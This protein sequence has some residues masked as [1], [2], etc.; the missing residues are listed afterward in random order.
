MDVFGPTYSIALRHLHLTSHP[1]QVA[2]VRPPYASHWIARGFSGVFAGSSGPGETSVFFRFNLGRG[3]FLPPD[4]SGARPAR[5]CLAIKAVCTG[6]RQAFASAPR[7][8]GTPSCCLGCGPRPPPNNRRSCRT[9]GRR[10]R[11]GCR[12]RPRPRQ[13]HDRASLAVMCSWVRLHSGARGR[14]EARWGRG[15]R[16]GQIPPVDARRADK[17][18]QP[19]PCQRHAGPS[20]R[21]PK[22]A[23]RRHNNA[24][25]V[26]PRTIPVSRKP[27]FSD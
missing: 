4:P 25:G 17:C 22:S 3:L 21:T 7:G 10:R 1:E 12:P 23:R 16:C 18:K 15:T 5:E 9:K 6:T 24:G 19:A 8:P 26:T 14:R 27:V 2:L 20:L 11:P 13:T